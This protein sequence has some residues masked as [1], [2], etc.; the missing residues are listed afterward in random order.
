M[1]RLL[2]GLLLTLAG[3]VSA[4]AQVTNPLVSA[5]RIG[6]GGA[7]ATTACTSATKQLCRNSTTDTTIYACDPVAGFY[8]PVASTG[9]VFTHDVYDTTAASGP[10]IHLTGSSILASGASATIPLLQA[11]ADFTMADPVT[12]PTIGTPTGVSGCL[13]TKNWTFRAVYYNHGGVTGLSPATSNQTG[14]ATSKNI[15][16]IRPSDYPPTATHWSPAF[17]DV[18]AAPSVVRNCSST[19]PVT[20]IGTSSVSCGCSG[21]GTDITS[22]VNT[23]AEKTIFQVM[24][25][26][27]R[28][29]S[30]ASSSPNLLTEGARRFNF[31]LGYASFTPDSGTTL[32]DLLTSNGQSRIVC[33]TCRYTTVDLALASISDNAVSKPYTIYALPGTYGGFTM[34]KSYVYVVGLGAP[35]SVIFDDPMGV[36]VDVT[37]SGVS[38][39]SLFELSPAISIGTNTVPTRFFI[40]NSRI[41][42]LTGAT[43]TIDILHEAGGGSYNGRTWFSSGSVWQTCWDGI[44]LGRDTR[45]VSSG[46]LFIADNTD[47]PQGANNLTM[48]NWISDAVDIEIS[49][50]TFLAVQT[51]NI[52]GAQGIQLFKSAVTGGNGSIRPRISITGSRIYLQSTHASTAGTAFHVLHLSGAEATT[53][54]PEISFTGTDIDVVAAGTTADLI[55]FN[56]DADA[57]HDGWIVSMTGGSIRRS[58]G[59]TANSYDIDNAETASGF[60]VEFNGVRHDGKYTGAGTTRILNSPLTSGVIRNTPLGTAPATCSIGDRYTDTSGAD[61]Y[62]S[63]SNTWQITN[64]T[65]SCV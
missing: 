31:G 3:I 27:L 50:A 60:A 1:R 25:G 21:S 10:I 26:E 43:C 54:N 45:F 2:A 40:N 15:P 38:N 36:G 24:D 58:G 4:S 57:D 32:F 49:G 30:F 28:F 39:V 22:Q 19:G 9:G 5:F 53:I 47:E 61:C 17:T 23:T 13:G 64:A 52:S 59:D 34:S 6:T 63:A 37:D 42:R 35:G 44:F 51:K 12:A 14:W 8:E 7:C 33:A 29:P 18:T 20:A 11:K 46:D 65:G 41:G 48:F 62:C 55:V 16:V 56:I